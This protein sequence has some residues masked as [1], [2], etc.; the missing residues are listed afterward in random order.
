VLYHELKSHYFL[1][2]A[3]AGSVA[4]LLEGS[5]ARGE[6]RPGLPERP[7][8]ADVAL[9]RTRFDREQIDRALDGA[10]DGL[11]LPRYQFDLISGEVAARLD[12]DA[13]R[14]HPTESMLALD[15]ETGAVHC[16]SPDA[17]DLLDSCDGERTVEEI[18]RRYGPDDRDMV[19]GFLEELAAGGLIR[20]QVTTEVVA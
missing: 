12:R 14:V 9:L 16:L 17:V 7:R 2:L 20:A 1:Y 18:V 4:K 8:R 3:K 5:F 15:R 10:Q 13:P 19:T 6:A 11:V